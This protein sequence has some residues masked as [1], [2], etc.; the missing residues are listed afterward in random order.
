[1]RVPLIVQTTSCTRL[2][3]SHL[4]RRCGAVV[5]FAIELPLLSMFIKYNI[6]I[7]KYSSLQRINEKS[8]IEFISIKDKE[9][10]SCLYVI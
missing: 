5:H 4:R 8:K 9:N 3:I 7:S 6:C 10:F 1:M 2:L